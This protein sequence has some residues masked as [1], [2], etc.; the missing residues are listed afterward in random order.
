MV[1]IANTGDSRALLSMQHGSRVIQLSTDHKPSLPS[2]QTRILAHGGTTYQ[3]KGP[4]RVLPGRLSVSRSFGDIQ[5]KLPQYGGLPN[6]ISAEPQIKKFKAFENYD[7]LF[8][9]CKESNI[10]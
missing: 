9:G 3:E 6:V 1:Y 2:E 10:R 7:F 8:L 5:A 4:V